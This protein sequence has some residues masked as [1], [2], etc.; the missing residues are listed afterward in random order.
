MANVTS[1]APVVLFCY[2]RPQHL[3]QT[4]SS[5]AQ[6]TLANVSTYIFMRTAPKTPKRNGKKFNQSPA[7]FSDEESR[8]KQVRQLIK[9]Q[10]W[11][12]SFAE[13]H[14]IES[15]ENQGLAQ[16]VIQGV[17]QVVEQYNQVIVL[18]D[19]VL[20]NPYFLEFMNQALQL[21][22]N[23]ERVGSIRAQ[24]FELPNPPELFFAQMNGDFAW[25]TW[26]RVWQKVNFNGKQLLQDL[27]PAQIKAQSLTT[28]TTIPIPKCY[29]TKL[30]DAIV[31]GVCV[32][33]PH[34]FYKIC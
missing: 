14:I 3:E 32:S 11:Q 16:T 7:T 2:N 20:L 27:N 19:D 29:E 1:Y 31:H 4:L 12:K 23:E 17:T 34:Y 33:M 28:I 25:G 22:Q 21:Y 6:N 10:R 8:I 24:V 9:E 15:S 26:Q 18:E 30:P 13:L 5:L